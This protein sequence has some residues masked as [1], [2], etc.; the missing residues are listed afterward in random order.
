MAR[1]NLSDVDFQVQFARSRYN[2]RMKLASVVALFAVSAVAGLLAGGIQVAHEF[3]EL[4][5][6]RRVALSLVRHRMTAP[7]AVR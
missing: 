2:A 7:S 1:V 5:R 4:I 3:A 6:S